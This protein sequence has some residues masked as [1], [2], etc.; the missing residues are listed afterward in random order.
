MYKLKRSIGMNGSGMQTENENLSLS[1]KVVRNTAK[2]VTS[3]SGK[4]ESD[5]KMCKTAVFHCQ[6]YKF[7][8]FLSQPSFSWLLKLPLM[9]ART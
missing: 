2:Q 3:S 9:A 5:W 6:M 8:T 7:A 4:E 1:V